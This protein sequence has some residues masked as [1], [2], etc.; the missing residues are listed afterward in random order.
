MHSLFLTLR[1]SI[2]LY[3]ISNGPVDIHIIYGHQANSLKP[4]RPLALKFALGALIKIHGPSLFFNYF[5]CYIFRK[6]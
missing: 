1:F 2:K 6:I 3:K 4:E 5:V